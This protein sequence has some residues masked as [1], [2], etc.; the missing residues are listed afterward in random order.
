VERPAVRRIES[1]FKGP[2]GQMLFRRV[3]LPAAEADATGAGRV[4]V[5]VHG[6]FEHSGRY[7]ATAAWFAARGCAV[8]A[9]DQLGHGRSEGPRAHARRFADLLD[10]LGAL[11]ALVRAEHAGLPIFLL[12]H[13]LGGLVVAA[14]L[15]EHKPDL[16]G[17]ITSG[18]A[19]ALSDGL[20]RARLLAARLLAWIAP[21]LSFDA[22]LDPQ[23]LSRDPEVVRAYQADP[24]VGRRITAALAAE[25]YGAVRRTAAGAAEVEVPLLLLHGEEDPLC[26]VRGSADFHA[27][28]RAPGRLRTYPRL[29]HEILNEPERA[30]VL[31][32]VL[33][34]IRR[35]PAR[36][37]AATP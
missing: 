16:A 7:D 26:P 11:L 25:L 5:L 17:A 30:M 14:F 22:G 32:D 37:A 24:L 34:W 29:R 28:L 27:R 12:G 18:A 21:R 4:L 13:S 2:R 1:H 9:Y 31:E 15:R 33:D 6:L 19:L 23:G 20:P 10:D 3:W 35:P 8:H 36:P